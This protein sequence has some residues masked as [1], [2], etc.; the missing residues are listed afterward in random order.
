MVVSN[1]GMKQRMKNN[2][3]PKLFKV[4]CHTLLFMRRVGKI[5]LSVSALLTFKT[6]EKSYQ[7]TVTL[8]MKYFISQLSCDAP[9]F[10]ILLFLAPESCALMVNKFGVVT[11]CLVFHKQIYCMLF[12]RQR[13]HSH[14]TKGFVRLSFQ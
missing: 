5:L 7:T 10:I 8:K 12:C 3:L 4:L 6:E 1:L 2:S 11:S 14:D 13:I 9:Y